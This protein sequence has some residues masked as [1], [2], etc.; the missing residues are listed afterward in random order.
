LAEKLTQATALYSRATPL[1]GAPSSDVDSSLIILL[2]T[3]CVCRHTAL[4]FSVW[5]SKG[6]GPLAFT[7][8]IRP[9][10]PPTFTPTPP[11]E[12]HRIRMS[13]ITGISRSQVAGVLA[14]AHGPFLLHLEPLDRIRLL[15]HMATTFSCLGFR[16]KEVYVLRE[17]LSTVMDLLVCSRDEA[18]KSARNL[19][20]PTSGLGIGEPGVAV[21][22]N[23]RAEGN[24]TIIRLVKYVCQVYGVDLESV[25]LVGPDAQG[26]VEV[27]IDEEQLEGRKLRYG[28]DEL[29]LGIVREAV[30]I[31][32]ALPG[33]AFLL[34][35]P[36]HF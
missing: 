22:E 2:L 27:G 32:E 36:R 4:L 18:L 8:L 10:L 34:A 21:R 16:R 6:W 9:G 15:Q 35:G 3:T 19:L 14:Q 25:K 17:V 23:E 11:N 30:A 12:S 1:P 31:V 29:Q 20:S 26:E 13:A 33:N 24:E 5:A 28:W 7:T